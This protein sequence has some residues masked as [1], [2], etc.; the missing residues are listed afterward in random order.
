MKNNNRTSRQDQQVQR[1]E[2]D[3]QLDS[4]ELRT[5]AR[6]DCSTRIHPGIPQTGRREIIRH[7]GNNKAV[8]VLSG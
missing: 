1:Q 7:N 6:L 2:K 5:K 4:R 3:N 8:K